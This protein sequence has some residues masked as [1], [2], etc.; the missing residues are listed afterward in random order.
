MHCRKVSIIIPVYNER[1]TIEEIIRRVLDIDLGDREREVIIVDNFSTD[2]TRDILQRLRKE[3]PV[4][5]IFHE[6]NKGIGVSLRDAI[7]AATGDIIVRQDADG[8]YLPEDIIKLITPIVSGFADIVFGSRLLNAKTSSYRYQSYLWGGVL[9]NKIIS[10]ITG[11][12]VTDILTAAKAFH[13]TVFDHVFLESAH[14]EVEAEITAKA[15]HHGLRIVEVP[16]S[17]KAR[18]FAEGKKIHWY[19]AFRILFAAAVYGGNERFI[20]FTALVV[21]LAA[22]G[23]LLVL[24][25]TIPFP[26]PDIGSDSGRYLALA[27]TFLETHQFF[28]GGMPESYVMP[29]YPLFLSLFLF[30]NMPFWVVSVVQAVLAAFSAVLVFRIGSLLLPKIGL[31]AAALFIFDP[32]GIY[33]SGAILT[34]QLF[35]FFFLLGV[36]FAL[37]HHTRPLLSSLSAGFFLG[38]TTL[39]RPVG[40]LLIVPLLIYYALAYS[41]Q[42]RR[43]I[44]LASAFLVG[45]F[46]LVM[47]WHIRNQALFG[48]SELSAV[49]AWQFAY[50]HA[51][52]FYA[53]ETGITSKN[54]VMLF[55]DKM[56]AISPYGTEGTLR[57]APYL[58]DVGLGYI[59]EHPARFTVFYG[60][61][62]IPFFLSD[63]MRD[64]ARRMNIISEPLPSLTENIFRGDVVFVMRYFY[65]SPLSMVL[66]VLG[67]VFWFV[68]TVFM[69]AGVISSIRMGSWRISIPLF[70]LVVVMAVVAGGAVSHARYRFSV[71]PFIYLT[72]A[73]GFF[74]GCNKE[75]DVS[76]YTMAPRAVPHDHV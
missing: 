34:E 44:V 27:H 47:P 58:W 37:T 56:R 9:I 19:H 75:R 57:N 17:Y 72:A 62:T 6:R 21:R 70:L 48:T 23:A 1:R 11:V 64:I 46:V 25:Q 66:F 39:I 59:K 65:Q 30:F 40:E 33:F 22:L 8:E 45:F 31:L 3:F 60:I 36:A 61:R 69:I 35:I 13:K 51:P 18:S 2:G 71:S 68:V 12:S 43:A 53:H 54:A 38:I 76:Y 74:A 41:N 52:L 67:V 5:V 16:V 24:S 10:W 42:C 49:A 32:I 50:A 55:D 4:R 29:L 28:V 63:G 73:A 7:A 20:F 14:F 15:A 26:F